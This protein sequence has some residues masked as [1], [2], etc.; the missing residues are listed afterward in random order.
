MITYIIGSIC[1]VLGILNFIVAVW[2]AKSDLNGARLAEIRFVLY[3][4]CAAICFKEPIK[5]EYNSRQCASGV[6]VML[7]DGKSAMSICP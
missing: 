2:I 3:L 7:A 6:A 1:I 4:I 5:V